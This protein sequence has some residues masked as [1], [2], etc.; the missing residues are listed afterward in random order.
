MNQKIPP[1]KNGV[2]ATPEK[3]DDIQPEPASDEL[4]EANKSIPEQVSD[5]KKKA[6]DTMKK[7][8]WKFL[9]VELAKLETF[10]GF[11]INDKAWSWIPQRIREEC[12]RQGVHVK[13]ARGRDFAEIRVDGNDV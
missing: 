6:L 7:K 4:F 12:Q 13:K 3:F 8:R 5:F 11:K 10:F 2:G 9:R 1:K